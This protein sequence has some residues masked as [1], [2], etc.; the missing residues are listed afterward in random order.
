MDRVRSRRGVR[1][2]YDRIAAHF[3]RTRAHAWADVTDF[4]DGRKGSLG[5]DV[6]CGNGRHAGPLAE[7]TDEVIGVDVSREVLGEARR[8]AGEQGYADS[9]A[10]LQG[11]GARLPVRAD[12]I[13]IALSIATIHHLPDRSSRVASL[14]ELARVLAPGGRALV[15]SWSVTHD[16]F[17]RT[18]GFDTTIDWTLPNDETVPRYYHIYDRAEF[19]ADL[20]AS[21]LVVDRTYLSHGNCF[22]E[23]RA[24][25]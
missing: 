5:L 7:R 22:G 25:E 9:L 14:D 6:G 18:T 17:E 8:R 1:E 19:D 21:A 10:L 24:P 23:V 12:T 16:R 13:D 20:T 4:L 15:S 3:A 2:T 11:D